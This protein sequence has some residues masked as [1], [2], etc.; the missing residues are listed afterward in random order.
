MGSIAMNGKKQ[1]EAGA[2]FLLFIAL[3]RIL[4]LDLA[5]VCIGIGGI[6]LMLN[7]VRGKQT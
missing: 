1:L 5:T 7:R 2:S 4:T 3:C 6:P